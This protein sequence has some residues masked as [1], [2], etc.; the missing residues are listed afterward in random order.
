[1][2][3]EPIER[4]PKSLRGTNV[5]GQ[6]GFSIGVYRCT[7][8]RLHLSIVCNGARKRHAIVEVRRGEEGSATEC[9][10]VWKG[11]NSLS[12]LIASRENLVSIMWFINEVAFEEDGWLAEVV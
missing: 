10:C 6:G 2:H 1:M 3:L 7:V 8:R 4:A 9:L 5:P 12:I 11:L